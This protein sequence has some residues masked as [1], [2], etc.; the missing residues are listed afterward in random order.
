VEPS[1]TKSN[2]LR[3]LPSRD[4]PNTDKQLPKRMKERRLRFEPSAMKSRSDT[5]L[6][7]LVIP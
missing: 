6:P 1:I 4:V 5:V 2:T 3:L 7:N